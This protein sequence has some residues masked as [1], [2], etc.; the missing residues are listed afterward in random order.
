MDRSV[1][2]L[3]YG[4]KVSKVGRISKKKGLKK[5]KEEK[6]RY[7]EGKKGRRKRNVISE[8]PNPPKPNNLN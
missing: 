5:K 6:R 2:S 4:K 1:L 3:N 8:T 7:E